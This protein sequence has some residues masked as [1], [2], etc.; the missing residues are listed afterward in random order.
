MQNIEIQCKSKGLNLTESIDEKV[1]ISADYDMIIRVLRNILDNAVKFTE[2]GLI[3]VSVSEGRGNDQ[4]FAFIRIKD[5]GIGILP[6]QLD[7]IFMEFRQASEGLGRNFE[8]NGLGLT[9]AKYLVELMMGEISVSSDFGKGSVFTI[10]LPNLPHATPKQFTQPR[11]PDKMIKVLVVDDD[12]FSA[13]LMHSF[14]SKISSVV[15]VKD[16]QSALNALKNQVFD[17][18]FLDIN[19][20]VGG[21]GIEVVKFIRQTE[22]I[23]AMPVIAVTGYT[24]QVEMFGQEALNYFDKFLP[25]PFKRS[26]ILNLITELLNKN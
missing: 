12:D 19:L 1:F 25:K 9:I 22:T 11:I 13:E 21:S 24:E 4:G 7:L 14:I 2:N 15:R 17:I 10:K 20:G 5:T 16:E 26:V 8:G 23:K 6:Q 18:A 3:D